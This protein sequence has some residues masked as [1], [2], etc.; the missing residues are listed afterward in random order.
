VVEQVGAATARVTTGHG[1]EPAP[2]S[3][4]PERQST[5]RP[6][7][8]PVLWL[9]AADPRGR[10]RTTVPS[11]PVLVVSDPRPTAARDDHGAVVAGAL[12][13]LDLSAPGAAAIPD[14]VADLDLLAGA[15]AVRLIA[16]GEP[17][18]ALL[19]R[20][21]GALGRR[22]LTGWEPAT[23][24]GALVLTLRGVAAP[25]QVV[26][27]G[28]GG[29]PNG[30][31]GVPNGPGGVPNGPDGVPTEPDGGT[32]RRIWSLLTL[33]DGLAAAARVDLEDRADLARR[34]ARGELLGSAQPQPQPQTQ[35][36]TGRSGGPTG[37]GGRGSGRRRPGAGRLV[38]RLP[39]RL[40]A[41]VLV[42]GRRVRRDLRSVGRLPGRVVRSGLRRRWLPVA[43]AAVPAGLALLLTGSALA[44][45]TA[46]L[47]AV[48]LAVLVSLWQRQSVLLRREQEVLRQLRSLRQDITKVPGAVL[49][50][51]VRDRPAAAAGSSPTLGSAVSRA[52]DDAQALTAKVE[53]ISDSLGHLDARRREESVK[54]YQQVEA[55]LNLFSQL[56]VTARMPGMRGW[57]VSPDLMLVLVELLRRRRPRVVVELG[58]GSSTVWLA[59]AARTFGLDT[60]II[61]LEH[62][63]EW[64]DTIHRRLDA[65]GLRDL[66]EVRHAPLLDQPVGGRSSGRAVEQQA[67]PWY[68]P[69]GW[70]DITDIGLLVVDGPPATTGPQ[71]RYPAIPMLA[72][73][74]AD[75]ALVVMDDA[76][77]ADERAIAEQWQPLL[78]GFGRLDLPVEKRAIIFHRGPVPEL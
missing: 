60:R 17:Q 3:L 49:D 44:A 14:A 55:A 22:G 37:A 52:A 76:V 45:G 78:A 57:A 75:D 27:N 63:Q 38:R 8:G 6:D 51:P 25:G 67:W 47:G 31:G 1:P 61:T 33:L 18:L 24:D 66:V 65:Q 20:L 72:S 4:A 15:G 2:P 54:G 23:D 50:V 70:R 41:P 36:L 32:D 74:L 30:P 10:L 13:V 48:L 19:A 29:V 28:P 43:V 62:D 26:P 9:G 11:G 77:R 64:V 53:G 42:L 46:L 68:A 12:V 16:S 71:A 21:A 73:R 59:L 56:P 5:R 69:T 7:P 39:P 34:L 58:G 40:R 35:P